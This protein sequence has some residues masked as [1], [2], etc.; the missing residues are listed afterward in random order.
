MID[1]LDKVIEQIKESAIDLDDLRGEWC[2]CD[3]RETYMDYLRTGR[4]LLPGGVDERCK[5]PFRVLYSHF[6]HL[7]NREEDVIR[8][9][10][11]DI[12]YIEDRIG[13]IWLPRLI[14]FATG[15]MDEDGIIDY[16]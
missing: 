10:D 15:R 16:K 7:Y 9:S 2:F 12:S 11:I 1:N 13:G 14:A 4:L 8:K 5:R 3:I 6:K